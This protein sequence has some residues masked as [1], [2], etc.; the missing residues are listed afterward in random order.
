MAKEELS[1][2][3]ASETSNVAISESAT[4]ALTISVAA[5]KPK[6]ERRNKRL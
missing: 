5:D 6:S 3:G 1:L 2:R 4:T